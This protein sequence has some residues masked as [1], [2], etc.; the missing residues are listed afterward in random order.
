M[1][2]SDIV[3]NIAWT[4]TLL[5]ALLFFVC[6]LVEEW[7]TGPVKQYKGKYEILF[8]IGGAFL[9]MTPVVWVIAGIVA[10]WGL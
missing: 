1:T 4:V 5:T 2:L 8:W 10:V 3:I 6:V 7:I 9:L